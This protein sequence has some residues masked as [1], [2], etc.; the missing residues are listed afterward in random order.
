DSHPIRAELGGANLA[1]VFY[2]LGHGL[3]TLRV[4]NPRSMI[5]RGRHDSLTVWAESGGQY[6]A[7]VLYRLGQRFAAPRV[8]NSRGAVA[9]SRDDSRPVGAELRVIHV[10]AMFHWV[11]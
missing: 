2:R 4:P 1:A 11:A 7:A 10:C 3:A 8:P 9:R 6:Y 5:P